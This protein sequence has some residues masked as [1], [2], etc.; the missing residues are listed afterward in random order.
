MDLLGSLQHYFVDGTGYLLIGSIALLIVALVIRAL[1][2]DEIVVSDGPDLRW[3][4][5][6][7]QFVTQYEI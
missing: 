7:R 1:Q 3:W 6:D 5:A 4:R 2:R